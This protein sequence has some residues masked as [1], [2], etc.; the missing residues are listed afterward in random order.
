VSAMP[1]VEVVR[2]RGAGT[3]WLLLH[4]V[5]RNALL[6][7]L[8]MAGLLFGELVGGA[9]VT[10]AV[11]GRAGVGQ[12][13]VQAVASRDSPVLLAVVVLSTV[14]YVVINLVVDLLYPVLDA[15][16]RRGGAR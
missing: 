2:A 14:A 9:V 15:R 11:F 1:F 12:L 7:T 10:E 6:P 13:T 8:T 5:G 4:G 16:L 3:P